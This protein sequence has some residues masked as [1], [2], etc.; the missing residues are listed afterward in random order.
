MSSKLCRTILLA[1]IVLALTSVAPALADPAPAP[2]QQAV[3]LVA[4]QAGC[5]APA[6]DLFAP[7]AEAAQCKAAAPQ[8]AA[9]SVPAF[10]TTTTFRGICRC[11]CTWI[12]NC[13]TSADCGGAPCLKAISC[14]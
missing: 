9:P 6:L 10:M 2:A 5:G 7:S 8:T 12:P 11:S 1:L 3:P 14:C 4:S 13:N